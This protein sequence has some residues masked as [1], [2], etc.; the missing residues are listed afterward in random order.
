MT[1]ELYDSGKTKPTNRG[2]VIAATIED[3]ETILVMSNI[4]IK[5]AKHD[6]EAST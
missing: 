2:N 5:T 4:T 1:N 6:R 3:N